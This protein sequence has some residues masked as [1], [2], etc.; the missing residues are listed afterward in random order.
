MA[1]LMSVIQRWL[2]DPNIVKL[3]EVGVGILIISIIFR[4][5]AQGLSHQVQDSDLRYRIRKI[6]G[7]VSYGV[8]ALLIVIVF[9]DNLRQLSVIFGGSWC[10]D[11]LCTA[12]SDRQLCRMDCEF[13]LGQFYKTGGS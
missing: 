10:G 3:I 4:I 6:L 1:N 13:S 5:L 7:F 9:N 8:I 2:A 11:C 12:R